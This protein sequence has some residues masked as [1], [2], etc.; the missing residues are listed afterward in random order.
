[1]ETLKWI[2]SIILV[3]GFKVTVLALYITPLLVI[4]YIK[5]L[6]VGAPIRKTGFA[7]FAACLIEGGWFYATSVFELPVPNWLNVIGQIG[8]WILTVVII[9]GTIVSIGRDI[10]KTDTKKQENTED[11]EPKDS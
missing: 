1:M 5:E 2:A 7:I 3:A 6:I 8:A 4:F 9:I 11:D 10:N